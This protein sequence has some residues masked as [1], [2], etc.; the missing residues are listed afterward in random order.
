LV[1][2]PP[3]N[4]IVLL[5]SSSTSC[6]KSR[7]SSK[8]NGH[9]GK[10]DIKRVHKGFW[11]KSPFYLLKKRQGEVRRQTEDVERRET[12]VGENEELLEAKTHGIESL[13]EKTEQKTEKAGICNYTFV[14]FF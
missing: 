9:C 8:Q 12:A 11:K 3:L 6:S 2:L 14:F 1:T 10:C 4:D 13:V 7:K 5:F